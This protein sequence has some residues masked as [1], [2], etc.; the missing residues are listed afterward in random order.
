MIHRAR[1]LGSQC[2]AIIH[3]MTFCAFE[4]MSKFTDGVLNFTRKVSGHNRP[5]SPLASRH[6]FVGPERPFTHER[7]SLSGGWQAI[8]NLQDTMVARY[9]KNH[10]P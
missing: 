9:L 10:G 4:G 8:L 2:S 6:V 1:I 5:E 7:G 3:N